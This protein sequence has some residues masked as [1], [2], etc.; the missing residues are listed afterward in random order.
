MVV[1]EVQ[2]ELDKGG[3]TVISNG[4][5]SIYQST[6]RIQVSGSGFKPGMKVSTPS[7]RGLSALEVQVSTCHMIMTLFFLV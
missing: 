7:Q 1:A 3:I 6:K 4:M 5:L 2:A